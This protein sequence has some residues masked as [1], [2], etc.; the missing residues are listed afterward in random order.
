MTSGDTL[1]VMAMWAAT[2][3]RTVRTQQRFKANL[4]GISWTERAERW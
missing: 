1:A 2:A 4:P 3:V